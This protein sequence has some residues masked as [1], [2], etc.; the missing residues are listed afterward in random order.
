MTETW[1][2]LPCWCKE[3]SGLEGITDSLSL[4]PFTS[5]TAYITSAFWYQTPPSQILWAHP[6]CLS[7]SLAALLLQMTRE[8]ISRWFNSDIQARNKEL[9]NKTWKSRHSCKIQVPNYKMDFSSILYF[10]ILKVMIFCHVKLWMLLRRLEIWDSK[11][12]ISEFT[13]GWQDFV[14]HS[15]SLRSA[16]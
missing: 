16:S 12:E 15:N 10:P 11:F 5:S 2:V 13:I 4:I 1:C 7:L 8:K 14:D 6:R 3:P 9:Q